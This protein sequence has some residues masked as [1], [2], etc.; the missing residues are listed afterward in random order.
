[1]PKIPNDSIISRTYF[2]LQINRGLLFYDVTNS[3][4]KD[5]TTV[6]ASRKMSII[7]INVNEGLYDFVGNPHNF[8]SDGF[9]T[10][11]SANFCWSNHT[12]VISYYYC[13]TQKRKLHVFKLDKSLSTIIFERSIDVLFGDLGFSF[14]DGNIMFAR[15]GHIALP[16]FGVKSIMLIENDGSLTKIEDSGAYLKSHFLDESTLPVSSDRLI[17]P[18]TVFRRGLMHFAVVTGMDRSLSS[19]AIYVCL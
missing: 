4:R 19:F 18:K 5:V 15:V 14:V 10:S 16:K 3:D 11:Y 13:A 6:I 17:D 8:P 7:S 2:P 12:V 1:M 9:H